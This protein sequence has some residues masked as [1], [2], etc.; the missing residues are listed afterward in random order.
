MGDQKARVVPILSLVS[1]QIV[2]CQVRGI[3]RTE[4]DSGAE[5]SEEAKYLRGKFLGR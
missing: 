4:E 5:L 2:G 1:M 3:Q